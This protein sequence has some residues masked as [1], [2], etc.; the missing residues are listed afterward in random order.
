MSLWDGSKNF[1]D[2]SDSEAENKEFEGEP[3]QKEPEQERETTVFR[4]L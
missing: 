2:K 4:G 3:E 1:F